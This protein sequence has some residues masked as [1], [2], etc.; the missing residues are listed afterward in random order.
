DNLPTVIMEAMACGLPVVST[1]LAGVPEMIESGV[2][3]WLVEPRCAEALAEAMMKLLADRTESAR[4][5]E[6]AQST[7]PGGRGVEKT[8]GELK[9][10]LIEQAGVEPTRQA[11][12]IDSG[13]SSPGWLARFLRKLG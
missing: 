2:D 12:E 1:R 4:I 5:G 3:G 10:L 7:A 6:G 9:R 8:T 11:R 13:L